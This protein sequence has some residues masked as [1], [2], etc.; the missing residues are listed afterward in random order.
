MAQNEYDFPFSV[1]TREAIKLALEEDVGLSDVTTDL[2]VP[3]Q[4]KA[5]AVIWS[6]ADGLFCGESIV[7]E[8]FYQLDSTL[9]VTS[10]LREGV[11]FKR[12]RPL[13]S[14]EGNAGAILRG[15]RTALNLL[16]RLCGIA[17]LTQSFVKRV[18]G[19]P[20]L[21]LDT[22]KTT[23]LWREIEKFLDG[24]EHERL[25]VAELF[26]GLQSPPFGLKAGILPI[27]LTAALLYFDS[28]VALYERGN[29]LPKLTLPIFERLC[30]APEAFTL[31]LCRIAGFSGRRESKCASHPMGGGGSAR[32]WLCYRFPS[33]A[34]DGRKDLSRSLASK[35][36]AGTNATRSV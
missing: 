7:Q 25:T 18:K 3:K 29:F 16:A 28:E 21:I 24:T 10:L 14:I 17:M 4:C 23:P 5:R 1:K 36:D 30:R 35:Y 31:Q 2:L 15:E 20:V 12:N 19:S 33:R 34:A 13:M 11:V 27:L 6:R 32:G 22:R 26:A 8:V 9:K